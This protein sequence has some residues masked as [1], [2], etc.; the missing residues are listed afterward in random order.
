MNR[1][2]SV[3]CIIPVRRMGR[4]LPDL[5]ETLLMQSHAPSHILL[6]DFAGEVSEAS[7]LYPEAEIIPVEKKE[8]AAGV[9]QNMAFDMAESDAVLL[10]SPDVE[11]GDTRLISRML[12][13]LRHA[14]VAASYARQIPG[15]KS[16]VTDA[17]E[18]RLAFPEENEIT[19]GGQLSEEGRSALR[20]SNVCAM[21][22]A[23]IVREVGGFPEKC[24]TAED[25]LMAGKLMQAGYSIAYCA[26]AEVVIDVQRSDSDCFRNAFDEGMAW[27]QHPEI[28]DAIP[29]LP[30]TDDW[31]HMNALLADEGLTGYR[32]QIA[33]RRHLKKVGFSLGRRYEKIPQGIVR[34]CSL[35]YRS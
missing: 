12:R 34:S 21:Y 9:L 13:P 28:T 5:Y 23:E 26:G 27:A 20:L 33:R 22:D 25:A 19:G 31:E 32:S 8:Q 7:E 18:M 2:P 29:L 15:P 30:D 17:C 14:D 4:R 10:L 3:D 1:N 35:R 24:L 16:G 6:L 11:I